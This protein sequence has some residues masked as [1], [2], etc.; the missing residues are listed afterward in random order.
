MKMKAYGRRQNK[1]TG[2]R[3][4]GRGKRTP[5]AKYTAPDSTSKIMILNDSGDRR[6]LRMACQY[7]LTYEVEDGTRK[8][9]AD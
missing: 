2:A 5:I 4:I 6:L 7:C 3:C 9:T 1:H 8:R